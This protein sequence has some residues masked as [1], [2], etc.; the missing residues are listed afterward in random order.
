M[1]VTNTYSPSHMRRLT[2]LCRILVTMKASSMR[3]TKTNRRLMHKLARGCTIRRQ[4]PCLTYPRTIIFLLSHTETSNPLTMIRKILI[5]PMFR[6]H[7]RRSHPTN[8]LRPFKGISF[9]Q[10]NSH[11]IRLRSISPSSRKLIAMKVPIFTLSRNKTSMIPLRSKWTF[12]PKPFTSLICNWKF[13]LHFRPIP[14]SSSRLRKT[15]PRPNWSIG[16]NY[17]IRLSRHWLRILAFK[18]STVL[19]TKKQI[20]STRSQHTPKYSI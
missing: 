17:S 3:R 4:I 16:L 14:T 12:E 18:E 15:K 8:I 10:P 2:S 1:I 20:A 13:S 19:K 5:Q 7:E 9:V 6:S 11:K